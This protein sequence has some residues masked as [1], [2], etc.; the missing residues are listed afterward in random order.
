MCKPLALIANRAGPLETMGL[1][2]SE[3][4]LGG[5]LDLARRID[6]FD[7]KQPLATGCSRVEPT[8]HGGHQ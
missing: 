2:G 7:A 1:K 4:H 5:P 3:N 6:I 8:G